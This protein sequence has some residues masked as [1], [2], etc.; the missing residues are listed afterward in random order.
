M[1]LTN[2]NITVNRKGLGLVAF[3]QDGIVGM[4]LSGQAIAD[5]LELNTPYSVFSLEDV[6]KLGILEMGENEKA[7]KQVKEFYDEAGEG[8]KLWLMVSDENLK[9]SEK[10]GSQ[11]NSPARILLDKANGEIGILAFV[12]GATTAIASVDGL[13][14]DVWES[15]NNAQMLAENYQGKMMPFCAIIDG[16]GFTGD[17]DVVKDLHTM[18]NHK[19]SVVLSAS[20]DDKIASVGQFLGRLAKN[21]VQ[22]K[23]SRVKDG[24]LTN[25]YGFLTDGATVDDRMEAMG[26]LHDKGYIV[27]RKFA[28]KTGYYFSGD[29]TATENTDDLNCI[30]RNRIIDK[31]TKIAYNTYVTELDDDVEVTENGTLQ[32]AVCAYLKTKIEQQVEVNTQD[33]ISS[34]VAIIDS[35]QNLLS[36]LPLQIELQIIP[37]G[38]LASISVQ[39]GFTNPFNK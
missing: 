10:I 17:A 18:S 13:D 16:L 9:M 33:E 34:F 38:Y 26:V 25:L 19:V 36:G 23:V 32:P 22:R 1:G 3:T 8:A 24:E 14:G 12:R 39:L 5:K 21:P 15:I 2:V 6:G 31:I 11:A 29:P 35:E 28:N 20:K 27:Y 4:C 7:Y 37:K 30:A